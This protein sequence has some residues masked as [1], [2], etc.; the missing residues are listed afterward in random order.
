[1]NQKCGQ[2]GKMLCSAC[3]VEMP[4][5]GDRSRQELVEAGRQIQV[6]PGKVVA[7]IF[8]I[9]LGVISGAGVYFGLP[10]IGA[11]IGGGIIGT[12]VAVW[13]KKM[14]QHRAPVYRTI[15]ESVEIGRSKCCI[16]CRQAV[17]HH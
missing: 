5:M 1:M 15:S 11:L 16:A 14:T 3:V 10:W 6:V 8:F 2:Y 4:R 17:Q 12:I 13:L 9:T 7:W